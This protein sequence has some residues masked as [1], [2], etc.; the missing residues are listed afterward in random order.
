MPSLDITVAPKQIPV[1]VQVIGGGAL[2][3]KLMRP[4][5]VSPSGQSGPSL[6]QV[7]THLREHNLDVI[8]K[9]FEV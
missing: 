6:D 2:P 8:H 5:V 4:V 1:L 7:L 9:T 3:D